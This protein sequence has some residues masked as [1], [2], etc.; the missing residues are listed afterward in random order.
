MVAETQ[1]DFNSYKKSL[2][3]SGFYGTNHQGVHHVVKFNILELVK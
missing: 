1:V 2:Q 3:P